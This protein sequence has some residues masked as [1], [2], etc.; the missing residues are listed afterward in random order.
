MKTRTLGLEHPSLADT[1][2]N[3][4]NLLREMERRD[5]ATKLYEQAME[6]RERHA[7]ENGGEG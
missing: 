7:R 5:E 3:Y 6:I 4:T 2:E 1:L